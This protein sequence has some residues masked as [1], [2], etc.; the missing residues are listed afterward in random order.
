M[1]T[2]PDTVA[3]MLFSIWPSNTQPWEHVADLARWADDAGW[4]AFWYADHYMPNAPDETPLDGPVLECWSVLAGVAAITSRLR[5]G[6]LVSPTTV[7][8]PT[9]L[10][11][12]ACT[13]DQMSGGRFILGVGAGWQVNEHAAYGFELPDVGP[14]VSRFAEA[15]EIMHRMLREPR[16]SFDGTWYQVADA[17]CDP[18]PVQDE[19][20]ILIG[21][22]SP[23]MMRLTARWAAQWNTW[24]DVPELTRKR[25]MFLAACDSVGRDPATIHRSAQAMVFLA[26]DQATIDKISSRALEGRTFVGSPAF[27]AD[28]ISALGGLGT[29]EFVLLGATLGRD[30]AAQ[31]DGYER[32]WAEVAPNVG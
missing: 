10:A 29:Q 18:K 2:V 20:P 12:R 15:L 25:E 4:H 11:K 5:L 22:A 1:R 28:Q 19:L 9:L 32:F 16:V 6:P 27:V 17:P 30:A 26:D 13:L 7:H 14:R 23:R 8:H 3:A 24:G 21:T 31:R